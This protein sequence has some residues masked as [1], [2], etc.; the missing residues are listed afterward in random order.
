MMSLSPTSSDARAI[1]ASLA[2]PQAFARVFDRHARRIWRYACRRVGPAAADEVVGETFLRAFAR[3]DGYDATQPDAAPWLYGIATNV[4][5]EHARVE[6]RRRRAEE[7]PAESG[8]GELDRAEARADAR[9]RVPETVA[10]LARLE[11]VDRDTLL[12]FALTELG[13]EQ[14]AAAMDVPVGTVRS[15]LHRARRAMR[16]E[17]GLDER[18]PR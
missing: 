14:I 4:L 1:R 5:R 13:Y 2:Q 6:A 11:R 15:R 7:R 3:R 17:L 10:A 16:T 12:L 8:D 9:A 18:S